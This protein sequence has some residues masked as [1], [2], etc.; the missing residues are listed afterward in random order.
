MDS[1]D[2]PVLAMLLEYGCHSDNLGFLLTPGFDIA[3]QYRSIAT[4]PHGRVTESA[5]WEVIRWYTVGRNH[6]RLAKNPRSEGTPHK[7]IGQ[8]LSPGL[9]NPASKR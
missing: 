9:A 4:D 2:L 5:F 8:D 6:T 3:H 7:V 1:D